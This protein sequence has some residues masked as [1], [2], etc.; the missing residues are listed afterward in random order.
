MTIAQNNG[1]T[2]SVAKLAQDT[3]KHPPRKNDR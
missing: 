2:A 1:D 3:K